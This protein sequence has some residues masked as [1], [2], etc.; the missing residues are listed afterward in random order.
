M[1]FYLDNLNNKIETCSPIFNDAKKFSLPYREMY[2]LPTMHWGRATAPL[3][4]S[5]DF[6]R[7]ISPAPGVSK[8]ALASA[9]VVIYFLFIFIYSK[10]SK[11]NVSPGNFW[12]RW[13]EFYWKQ[14]YGAKISRGNGMSTYKIFDN[15]SFEDWG[16]H[17]VNRAGY[18]CFWFCAYFRDFTAL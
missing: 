11:T 10:K 16:M 17:A 13:T 6:R 18:P 8:D 5:I 14:N 2:Y 9:V 15:K 3:P 4:V 7:A 1:G 12:A